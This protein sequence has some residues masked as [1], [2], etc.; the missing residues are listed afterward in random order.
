MRGRSTRPHSRPLAATY[1]A[2]GML[3]FLV[4]H[5]LRPGMY[6]GS[7]RWQTVLPP[8]LVDRTYSLSAGTA[9]QWHWRQPASHAYRQVRL[10][11]SSRA[12]TRTVDIDTAVGTWTCEGRSGAMT[13]DALARLIRGDRVADL[14]TPGTPVNLDL[15]AEAD[16]LLRTVG[17]LGS[18]TFTPP[19]AGPVFLPGPPGGF[20]MHSTG[21]GFRF[22]RLWLGWLL[23]WPVY[24]VAWR[25]QPGHPAMTPRRAWLL[26][27][28]GAFLLWLLSTMIELGAGGGMA[29][30]VAGFI[31]SGLSL[32]GDLGERPG[33][34]I[35]LVTMLLAWANLASVAA[36]FLRPRRGALGRAFPVIVPAPPTI[37]PAGPPLPPAAPEPAPMPLPAPP[38]MGK[39]PAGEQP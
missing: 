28:G 5:H 7:V 10:T 36:V 26:G 34:T 35:A 9:P 20:A 21:G 2:A 6:S 4:G 39:A 37:P 30:R 22:H 25:A 18:G 15:A 24:L 27:G 29:G 31:A 32:P 1:F 11:C 12:G 13:R 14:A 33:A 38:L 17:Q 19:Q 3:L 23:L 16:A 8:T